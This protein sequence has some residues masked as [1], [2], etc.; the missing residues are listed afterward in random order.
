[1]LVYNIFTTVP[2]HSISRLPNENVV[3]SFYYH[4]NYYHYY[5]RRW[6]ALGF[7]LYAA[8][9]YMT[10]YIQ[11][12][13]FPHYLYFTKKSTRDAFSFFLSFFNLLN[14]YLFICI[15]ILFF[16]LLLIK[17]IRRVRILCASR[18]RGVRAR[19]PITSS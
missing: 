7:Y 4:R 6:W 13:F 9:E 14:V 3:S 19:A 1:M 12:Y 18:K 2:I 17:R 8:T 15:R 11:K 5:Y 16:F 10:I